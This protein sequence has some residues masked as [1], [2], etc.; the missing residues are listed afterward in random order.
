M[1]HKIFRIGY[2]TSSSSRKIEWQAGQT[3][4]PSK[5]QW[6]SSSVLFGGGCKISSQQLAH[7]IFLSCSFGQDGNLPDNTSA[8]MVLRRL[9]RY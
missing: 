5:I 9:R 3:S 7:F 2:L 4:D 1:L 6:I 8:I